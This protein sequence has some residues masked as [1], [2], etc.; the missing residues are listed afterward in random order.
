MKADNILLQA[1]EIMKE[2][3]FQRD[4]G[5]ER[6]M[7]KVVAMQNAAFGN[8]MTEQEGWAFMVFLKIARGVSGKFRLDDFQDGA[9]YMA[10]WGECELQ[11]AP[12]AQQEN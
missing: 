6:V 3:A 4:V 5:E 1:A 8:S 7:A 11:E 12:K 10:L 9:A 2:R